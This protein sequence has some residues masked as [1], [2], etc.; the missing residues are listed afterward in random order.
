MKLTQSIFKT[1]FFGSCSTIVIIITFSGCVDLG[2]TGPTGP[3]ASINF[4]FVY[5]KNTFD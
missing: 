2:L 1:L 5:F 3:F 4:D